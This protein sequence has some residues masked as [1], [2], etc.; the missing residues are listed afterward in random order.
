VL[1]TS[2]AVLEYQIQ[3]LL[4]KEGSLQAKKMLFSKSTLDAPAL[5]DALLTHR[6]ETGVGGATRS[7]VQADGGI[8]WALLGRASRHLYRTA[9]SISFM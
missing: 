9:P 7:L 1:H 4:A 6:F 2:E 5:V 8:D 3:A